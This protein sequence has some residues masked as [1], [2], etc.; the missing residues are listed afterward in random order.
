MVSLST[1]CWNITYGFPK[2]KSVR[3]R[4]FRQYIV[5]QRIQR[6]VIHPACTFKIVFC[7]ESYHSPLNFRGKLRFS[8]RTQ[9]SFPLEYFNDPFFRKS[10]IAKLNKTGTLIGRIIT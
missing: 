4:L 7:L 2:D 9:L 8:D 6:I 10:F 5:K 3:F 1:I